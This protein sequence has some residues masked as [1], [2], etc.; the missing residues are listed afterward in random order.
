VHEVVAGVG[1][2]EELPGALGVRAVRRELAEEQRD[3][4]AGGRAGGHAATKRVNP[5][6]SQKINPPLLAGRWR[7]GG[8]HTVRLDILLGGANRQDHHHHHHHQTAVQVVTACR[9][10]REVCL[11]VA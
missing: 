2:A 10:S 1:V 5:K 9:V 11:R 4:L 7:G 6:N 8:W 3:L